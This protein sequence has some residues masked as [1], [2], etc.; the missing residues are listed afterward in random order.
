MRPRLLGCTAPALEG[1][2]ALHLERWDPFVKVA[3]LLAR[4]RRFLQANARVDVDCEANAAPGGA[5]CD[6]LPRLASSL[7]QLGGVAG[8]IAPGHSLLYENSPDPLPPLRSAFS[9]MRRSEHEVP[10]ADAL[11]RRLAEV[12][13]AEAAEVA[14]A[15]SGAAAAAFALEG[16]GSGAGAGK[17]AETDGAA[18]GGGAERGGFGFPAASETG[19]AAAGAVPKRFWSKGTG[20]GYD[21]GH[22]HGADELWDSAAAAAAQGA[23][24]DAVGAIVGAVLDAFSGLSLQPG[25]RS[26]PSAAA[27]TS[28]AALAAV[29]AAPRAADEVVASSAAIKFLEQALRHVSF[30][31]MCARSAYYS[32]LLHLAIAAAE[33][34]PACATALGRGGSLG[35]ATHLCAAHSQAALYLR[36]YS[37]QPPPASP[38]AA[39]AGPQVSTRATSIAMPGAQQPPPAAP[40]VAAA[41]HPA[42]Q[43]SERDGDVELAKA[44]EG[45]PLPLL[46]A[47]C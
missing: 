22:R 29:P 11:R 39:S 28:A 25:W 44:I 31:D 34:G 38:S 40:P 15:A 4:L 41:A 12:A 42:A 5:Y 20:Y 10:R 47:Q 9:G 26:L 18:V 30:S 16:E 19:A 32:A 7:A 23:Q 13:A 21:D 3:D 43:A 14:A 35:V 37:T 24:D 36:F 17:K 33:A 1:H 45:L 6:P 46:C 2:P 8:I 27:S